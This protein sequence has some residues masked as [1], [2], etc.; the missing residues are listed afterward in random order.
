[1]G[2]YATAAEGDTFVLDNKID[3]DTWDDASLAEKNKAL[4]VAT[5][6]IDKINYI[7]EQAVEGQDNQFPRGED[8]TVPTQII[9]ATIE[10]AFELLDGR[11]P[12]LELEN[13]GVTAQGLSSARTSYDRSFAPPHI[14][15]GI[16]SPLAWNLL[17]P[18]LRDT[19]N[20]GQIRTS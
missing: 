9:E 20:I 12:M 11:N 1:M 6:A 3:T 15:A 7:G 17:R 14:P 10:E 18:F 2:A 13:L 4:N 19:R 16:V 8:T 5:R